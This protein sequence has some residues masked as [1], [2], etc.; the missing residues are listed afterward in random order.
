MT[1]LIPI[2]PHRPGFVP[3]ASGGAAP[4]GFLFGSNSFCMKNAVI[5]D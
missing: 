3:L 1:A 5:R 2:Q 4:G